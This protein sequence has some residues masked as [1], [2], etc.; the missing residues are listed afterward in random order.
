MNCWLACKPFYSHHIG[1]LQVSVDAPYLTWGHSPL[2]NVGLFR[3]FGPDQYVI[4]NS[5]I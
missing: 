5:R 3:V 2:G 4:E 1:F